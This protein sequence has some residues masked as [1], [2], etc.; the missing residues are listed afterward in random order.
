MD[1]FERICKSIREMRIQGAENIAK[2]GLR[3]LSLRYNASAAKRLISLRPTE[4]ALRNAVRFAL[5]NSVREALE[6]FKKAEEKLV[7]AGLPLVREKVFTHCHS[8]SVMKILH[9]A[10]KQGKKFVVYNTET[11]PLY[12]GRITSREISKLGIRNVH[13]VDSAMSLLLERCDVVLIGA[14]AITKKGVVNKIG[15]G[16]VGKTAKL[17]HVPLYVCAVGWKFT[18]KIEIERRDPKEVWL[19]HPEHVKVLN[20]SFEL[21]EKEDVKAVVSEFG[22]LEFGKFVKRAKKEYPWV[23]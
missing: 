20:P 3:G 4:P 10:K 6:Y 19:E 23:R 13:A 8:S 22:V 5:K 15:S 21:V 16:L 11:R 7:V 12:Q 17:L 2:A 1:E 9:A 18:E 14:D